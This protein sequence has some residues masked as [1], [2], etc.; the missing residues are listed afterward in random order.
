LA[1]Q[2]NGVTAAITA[3]LAMALAAAVA[4][5]GCNHETDGPTDAVRAFLHASATGNK[6]AAIKLLGP[7]TQAQLRE[8][9]ERAT[10][11]VGGEGRY[12]PRDMIQ[13]D[14]GDPTAVTI[15]NMGRDGDEASL[16]LTD[17]DGNKST[18]ITVLIDGHWRL[19][20]VD[21]P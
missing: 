8:A 12:E 9:A 6:D 13:P 20:L 7:K 10:T 17:A 15:V 18:V 21:S 1:S 5:R 11:L 4:G 14:N 16:S 19:E 3:L 2:A